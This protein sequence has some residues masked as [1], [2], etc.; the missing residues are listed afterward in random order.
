MLEMKETAFI[1]NNA[2]DR[3]LVLLDELGRATSNEDGVA[4][5][6]AVCEY[7]MKKRAMTFFVT[8]YPQISQLAEIY[9][10]VQN[11]FL[12]ANITN[13]GNESEITYTHR[14]KPGPLK[15]NTDYGVSMAAA[16][17]WPIE[18]IT[19]AKDLE[20]E[21][22]RL[23]PYESFCDPD[24][25]NKSNPRQVACDLLE[26]IRFELL[27][28]VDAERVQSY[29]SLRSVLSALQTRVNNSGEEVQIAIDQILDRKQRKMPQR[30]DQRD[31]S[32]IHHDPNEMAFYPEANHVHGNDFQGSIMDKSSGSGSTIS[33]SSS[34]D[35]DSSSEEYSEN[36]CKRNFI[37]LPP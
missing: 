29:D 1:C 7:L 8:H 37:S 35:L 30:S 21:V 5:A 36:D 27:S 12:D 24:L 20:K 34:S 33:S 9:P 25:L 22:K 31:G 16:C 32:N 6:W 13:H 18:A 26:E 15:A 23:L 17:G 2:T 19:I 28:L 14:V 10:M 4:I 11:V 3:S